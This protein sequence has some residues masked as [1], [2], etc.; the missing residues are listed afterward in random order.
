MTTKKPRRNTLQRKVVL[1]ELKKLGSHPTAAELYEI[2]RARLPRIS[3][4]TVYR[5]LEFL[6]RRGLIRK[7]ATSGAE[8]RFDGNLDQ[9]YHVRCVRCGRVDDAHGLPDDPVAEDVNV[10]SGYKILGF[11]LE[12]TGVCPECQR[13]TTAHD[14]ETP[15]GEGE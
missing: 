12:F 7:L 5:N 3:L 10:L 15:P 11:H 9:H 1:E 2:T 14:D 4:G 13:R 8:A 6:S